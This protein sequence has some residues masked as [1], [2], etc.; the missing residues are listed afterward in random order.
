[1]NLDQANDNLEW[2]V[3]RG[4][5]VDAAY[6]FCERPWAEIFFQ[7]VYELLLESTAR[8]LFDRKIADI[9]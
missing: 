5:L 9:Q 6:Y 2:K 1:M 4:Y 8:D 3:R 7:H